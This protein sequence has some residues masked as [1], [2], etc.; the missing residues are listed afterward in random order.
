MAQEPK[1][2]EMTD[3]GFHDVTFPL[4]VG[5]GSSGGPERRTDIV[6]LTSGHEQRNARWA[7]SRR[8]YDAGIGVRSLEDMQQVI[9]FFEERCGRLY[10]FRFR[11]PLDHSSAPGN[12][13]PSGLDQ[14]LGSGD[15]VK[16]RFQL[17]KHYG[18]GPTAYIRTIAKPVAGSVLVAVA[19]EQINNVQVDTEV[20]AITLSAPP[21]KDAPITAGFLFDVPVR[22]DIDRLELSLTGFQAGELPSIPMVELRQ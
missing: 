22:F 5:F 17:Q 21:A 8:S 3:F 6:A 20:G 1:R 14:P 11:D 7:D 12:I 18:N 10:G 13:P 19:G 16:T 2:A 4:H 9:D 15:G